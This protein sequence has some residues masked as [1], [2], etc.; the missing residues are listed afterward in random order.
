MYTVHHISFKYTALGYI[1]LVPSTR[2]S[3]VVLEGDI[4]VAVNYLT[5][6]YHQPTRQYTTLK[7]LNL[8][9]YEQDKPKFIYYHIADCEYLV[10]DAAAITKAQKDYNSASP[11]YEQCLLHK[12][13]DLD[14][15]TELP[16]EIE[17]PVFHF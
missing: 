16:Q 2:F 9:D 10:A 14:F 8:K 15:V 1:C 3:G 13:S 5:N 12:V 11:S 4:P 6:C 7:G 17:L